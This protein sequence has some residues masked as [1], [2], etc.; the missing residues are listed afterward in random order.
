VAYG[1]VVP[2]PALCVTSSTRAYVSWAYFSLQIALA[3]ENTLRSQNLDPEDNSLLISC[4]PEHGFVETKDNTGSSAGK[5]LIGTRAFAHTKAGLLVLLLADHSFRVSISCYI[6][7]GLFTLTSRSYAWAR[8]AYFSLPLPMSVSATSAF[9]PIISA[10]VIPLAAR[11]LKNRH[12]AVLFGTVS[13]ILTL[14]PVVLLTLALI[15]SVPSQLLSCSLESQWGYLF[16]T[17]NVGA[18]RA[19]QDSLRC[20]GLNS[21]HDRAW[22]FPSK[23][24]DARECERTQGWNV[25]CLDGWTEQE[26]R[27]A[28]L[29][30]VASVMNWA[31]V[32]G[33]L[34]HVA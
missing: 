31:F 29:V 9:Y 3:F 27:M 12:N 7:N 15:Y 17:K 1:G 22:P 13:Y 2:S 30:A 16:R 32:V 4:A 24:V 19:I 14:I 6:C 25:R 33:D 28:G 10:V 11:T 5:N 8:S 18:V 21:M 23:G 26:T 34:R 20:C